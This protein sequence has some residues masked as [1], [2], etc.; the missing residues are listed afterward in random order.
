[1]LIEDD[2]FVHIAQCDTQGCRCNNYSGDDE[3]CRQC[4]AENDGDGW[5][6]LCGNCADRAE[7]DLA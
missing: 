5:D 1:M 7:N 6:G 2:K 4:K 3:Y